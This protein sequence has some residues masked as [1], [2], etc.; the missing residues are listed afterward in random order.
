[1]VTHVGEERISWG[2]P[3]LPSQDSGVPALR[4]VGVLLY[5]WLHLLSQNEQIRHGIYGEG[6]VLGGQL[7][8]CVC[9]NVPD[10]QSD[11]LSPSVMRVTAFSIDQQFTDENTLRIASFPSWYLK[12]V[13]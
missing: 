11:V 7:R 6:H 9:I 13:K 2:Q 10:V 3:R 8:H 5:S 4:N 12:Q 1:M